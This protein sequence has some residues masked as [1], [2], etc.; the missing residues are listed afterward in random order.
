[1]EVGS[2][3]EQDNEEAAG[4]DN[5]SDEIQNVKILSLRLTGCSVAILRTS[6]N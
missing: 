2:G 1:M 6:V 5:S 3:E 4:E